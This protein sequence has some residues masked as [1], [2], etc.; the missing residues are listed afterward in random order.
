MELIAYYRVST[1]GQGASGLGLEAQKAAVEAYARSV[2]GEIIAEYEEVESGKLADRPIL[3]K[4]LKHAGRAR[5]KLVIAK[6]D[7]LARNVAFLSALMES[8][9][10]FVA[11][12]QPAASRLTIHILAA[13]AEDEALRISQRTK[14]A[15]GAAKARGVALGSA[16]PGHWDGREAARERGAK[17]GA[18]RSGRAS[19]RRAL[20]KI[21]DLLPEIQRRR[22]GGESFATIA[23]ALNQAGQ[24]TSANGDWSSMAVL[25]VIKREAL[26]KA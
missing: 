6:L 7:R 21:D 14:A 23:E 22:Q 26:L 24:R 15:L 4:A 8:S 2:G 17:L 11:C 13:V 25:R 16:R 19:M 3:A 9:V 5:C 12:D 1:K 20:E 18:K 10:E